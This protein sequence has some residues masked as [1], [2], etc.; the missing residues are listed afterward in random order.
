MKRF[1]P[2]LLLVLALTCALAAPALGAPAVNGVFPV[3]GVETNDKLVAG[4]DGNIWVTASDGEND[5][6]RITPSGE[7]KAFE[8]EGMS[9]VHGITVGP[10]GRLWVTG[11][12]AVASFL[13]SDPKGTTKATTII[14]IAGP[15]PIVT[16]PDGKL[17]VATENLVLRISPAD[18]KV[19]T[20]FP[21]AGLA[22]KDIDVAGSLL[23][24]ADG[25]AGNRIV[26]LT[27]A[28]TEVDFP[29]GGA[30]QGVA[31][32]AGGQ[33]AF[34]AP[35][36]TPEQVGLISP[37]NPPQSSELLG[38][39]FGV[40]VGADQAYWIV[41]FAQGGLTRMTATGE[42]TFLGGLPKESPRQIAPGP[43]NT[44]WVTLAKNEAEGVARIS[45]L[46]PPQPPPPPPPTE[47]PQTKLEKG[48]KGTV[49]TTGKRATV[50]FRF[51]SSVAGSSF[52][53]ALVK[54]R[55][56]K[57]VKKSKRWPQPVFKSCKSPRTYSLRPGRYR[58]SVKALASGEVDSSPATRAFR[59]V[60][61]AKHSRNHKPP[62]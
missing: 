31:G 38:D 46:E 57:K 24:V 47:A 53:C 37:P 61:V 36:A 20:P 40:A 5:V 32:G 33:I 23:A 58:F 48:P 35:G 3:K 52:E 44:L 13:P 54:A 12:N 2:A 62:A 15:S 19:N 45:G 22:P 29:I 7:V 11:V 9:Q 41:Q 43:D 50:K 14:S 30:S 21:V 8:L 28:G 27:T 51:S 34:S 4:P 18:P 39:P 60:H 17:W 55:E 26:T 56:G 10:E 59:V 49:K 1:A 6:A 16:G 25:G 42:K